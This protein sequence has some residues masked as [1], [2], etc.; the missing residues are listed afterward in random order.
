MWTFKGR[1]QNYIANNSLHEG[2]IDAGQFYIIVNYTHDKIKWSYQWNFFQ[3]FMTIN[4]Y[5]IKKY[6][7]NRIQKHLFATSIY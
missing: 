1:C 4:K 3:Y 5:F 6:F 2:L 7:S